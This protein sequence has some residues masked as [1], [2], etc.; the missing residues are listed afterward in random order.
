MRI[1]IVGGSIAGCSAAIHLARANH[2]VTVFERSARELVGRGAGIGTPSST[3]RS[4]I[5]QDLVD[6]DFPHFVCRES[7]FTAR[8]SPEDALGRTAWTLPLDIALFHWGDL[9]RNLRRRVPD[10]M[11]RAG[12]AVEGAE[13]SEDGVSLQLSDGATEAFE[14]VLFADGYASMGRQ[15]F[16][17]EVDLQYRGYV[18]WRGVLPESEL[19]DSGPLEGKLPR[20]TYRGTAGHTVLY[21]VP[22]EDGAVAP[23]QR[24]V[25]WAA[26]IPVDADE[27]PDLLTDAKG[28]RHQSSLPPG[29]MRQEW[30]SRLTALLVENL[31]RYY[32]DIVRNTQ[33]SFV[34]PIYTVEMPSYRRGCGLFIGDAGAVAQ[35]FTGSG[36]FKGFNNARELVEALQSGATL[37]DALAEWDHAQVGQGRRL[38][39]LGEQMERAFIWEPLDFATAEEDAVAQWWKRS[40][41]FP[42][43]FSYAKR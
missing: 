6:E 34:Q 26:Y 33:G 35:P 7:P 40:V 13:L 38:V 1:G 39:A 25:N 36:I 18:L 21:F 24:L 27:L 17:S 28:K 20:L 31:P 23:G 2:D 12:V 22:G 5:E 14:L 8:T 15:W 9:F 37:N 42:E 29:G 3:L 32:G 19:A 30:V 43:D 11:Y 10:E 41:T 4:L 16:F